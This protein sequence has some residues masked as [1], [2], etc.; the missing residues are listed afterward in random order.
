MPLSYF[1]QLGHYSL[2]RALHST[3]F[4]N[5]GGSPEHDGAQGT[6]G[7]KSLCLILELNIFLVIFF[8]I[9]KLLDKDQITKF[10]DYFEIELHEKRLRYMDCSYIYSKYKFD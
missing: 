4:Q 9:L 8:Q 5:S 1:C 2:T 3:P 10:Y 6:D 7:R